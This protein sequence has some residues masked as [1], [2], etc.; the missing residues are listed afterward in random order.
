MVQ[1][2][3]QLARINCTPKGLMGPSGKAWF[4]LGMWHF[5]SQNLV[6]FYLHQTCSLTLKVY[7]I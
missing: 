5:N 4:Y 2:N 1:R 3:Q 6:Q 7:D